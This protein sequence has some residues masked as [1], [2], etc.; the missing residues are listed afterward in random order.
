MNNTSFETTASS[1]LDHKEETA[2]SANFNRQPPNIEAAQHPYADSGATGIFLRRADL[3]PEMLSESRPCAVPTAVALPNGVVIHSVAVATLR[4]PNTDIVLHVDVFL[5]DV[6]HVSLAGVSPFTAAGCKVMF[7]SDGVSVLYQGKVVL[8]GAKQPYDRLWPIPLPTATHRVQSD[9]TDPHSAYLIVRNENHRDLVQFVHQA[10]GSPTQSGFENALKKD[11]IVFPGLTYEQVMRNKTNS[12]ATA[13]GHLNQQLPHRRSPAAVA[14]QALDNAAEAADD[15]PDYDRVLY[16]KVI[17]TS[18]VRP[19][20]NFSDATGQLPYTSRQGNKYILVSTYNNHVHAVPIPSRHA[21]SYATAYKSTMEYHRKYHQIVTVQVLDNESSTELEDYISRD[22]SITLQKVPPNNHRANRSERHIRTFK[23]HTISTLASTDD[24]CPDALWEDFLQQILLTLNLLLPWK[25][26]PALSAYHG[27]TGARYDFEAHPIAPCGMRVTIFKS[28]DVRASW[29]DHGV[30][31]FYLGPSLTHHRC[32]RAFDPATQRVLITDTLAWF[33]RAVI[34]PGA[35]SSEIIATSVDFLRSSFDSYMARANLDPALRLRM[36]HFFTLQ[37]MYF[38]GPREPD[39]APSAARQ[40]PFPAE[41]RVLPSA[42]EQRVPDSAAE[43]RV[44]A[45]AME[46]RVPASV[47][48][49][50]FVPPSVAAQRIPPTVVAHQPATAPTHLSPQ[51]EL[52]QTAQQAPTAAAPQPQPQQ[53]PTAVPQPPT[54]TSMPAPQPTVRFTPNTRPTPAA[55]TPTLPAKQSAL[56]N[57]DRALTNAALQR[58]L[59]PTARLPPGPPPQPHIAAALPPVS[60]R[61][62]EM[63]QSSQRKPPTVRAQIAHREDTALGCAQLGTPTLT[64]PQRPQSPL[65]APRPHRTRRQLRYAKMKREAP[66][67]TPTTSVPA[68]LPL[69]PPEHRRNHP[70]AYQQD[71]ARA[72]LTADTTRL[73]LSPNGQPLTYRAAKEGPDAAYWEQA[74]QEEFD[75]LVLTETMRPVHLADIPSERRA[76]ITYYNPQVKEKLNE[77]QEKIFRVRGTLGGDRLNYPFDVTARTADLDAVKILIHSV[78]SDDGGKYMT[79][80]VS[81]YYLGTDLE[82][83]EYVR[84]QLKLIPQASMDKHEWHPYTDRNSVLFEVTKGCYGLPQAGKLAQDKL[85]AHLAVH[86]YLQCPDVPCVFRHVTRNVTFSL[87]VD[88]FGIKYF[89]R[90]DAE[91]LL[92]CLRLE[93]KMTVNWKG[94]KYLGMQIDFAPDMRSV[95]LSLPGYIAKVLARFCPDSTATASAPGVYV[96]PEYGAKVQYV[97]QDKS[98]ALDSPGVKRLREIVGCL[99]YYARVI[100]YTMLTVLNEIASEQAYATQRVAE[101]A[102]KLLA[103]ARKFPNHAIE[104]KACDMH[105]HMQSDASYLSRSNARSVSGGIFYLGNIDA[106]T[107]INGATCAHSSIIPGVPTAATEAEYCALFMNGKHGMYLRTV[108]YNLGYPQSATTI[109]C[110]NACATGIACDTVKA[111]RSKSIDMRWHWIRNAVREGIYNVVWRK[112]AYNLADFFTKVLPVSQHK[113]L[114]PFIVTTA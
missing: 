16:F 88:D 76:D 50:Q 14:Q 56:S 28:S 27:F 113:V 23:E 61:R 67:A 101:A 7:E 100:D 73:N 77:E 8:H 11:Y 72:L 102:D 48:P 42:A 81:D 19:T 60:Q 69:R 89:N 49:K 105:L 96:A 98:P 68:H 103:Y 35:S 52:Q 63:I 83:P 82:R 51:A 70:D 20:T 10:F 107:D 109:L 5:N 114:A 108:L 13:M 65:E 34:M 99:L 93:Y 3:T 38:H 46:Q 6:L 53:L 22:E 12:E 95:K 41:Q 24:R 32:Y 47:L 58:L 18:S 91:H 90:E 1:F 36:Q 64:Q 4:V 57:S 104:F 59:K 31:G 21:R 85:I 33:P 15:Q 54:T 26:N 44:P 9:P 94:D 66:P 62:N 86:G 30:P 75:R 110:D 2:H 17:K 111:K 79:A 39:T 84:I 71:M 37:G 43:Q 112:G 40:L 29:G 74:E 78:V 55:H 25:L 87:V 45:S 92:Q 97:A 106:P 80:D